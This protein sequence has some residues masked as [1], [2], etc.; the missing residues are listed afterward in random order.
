MEY[1][2]GYTHLYL[3]IYW[4]SLHYQR[5]T[6]LTM[7]ICQ[8]EI[9]AHISF[10]IH[11]DRSL[12]ARKG[13]DVIQD[14]GCG[15]KRPQ[16]ASGASTHSR[17]RDSGVRHPQTASRFASAEAW[18]MPA[19]LVYL[20]FLSV[21][22]HL[23]YVAHIEGPSLLSSLA[24][25]SFLWKDLERHPETCFTSFLCIFQSSQVDKQDQPSQTCN[26]NADLLT[27]AALTTG[28]C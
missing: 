10:S 6:I 8:M 16:R 1:V 18:V 15:P 25:S 23:D 11:K 5:L 4:V 28:G 24:H 19:S 3:G 12:R 7:A 17:G 20:P 26:L 13:N 21:P 9:W 22:Q 2:C 27:S 14:Q